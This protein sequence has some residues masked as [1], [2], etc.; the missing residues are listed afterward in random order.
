MSEK[1]YI[2]Y[3]AQVKNEL[4]GNFLKWCKEVEVVSNIYKIYLLE[5]KRE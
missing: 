1:N 2:E 4:L 3:E 5:K